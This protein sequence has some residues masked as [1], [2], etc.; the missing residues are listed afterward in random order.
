MSVKSIEVSLKLVATIKHGSV[1][2]IIFFYYIASE[3]FTLSSVDGFTLKSEW[4]QVPSGLQDS[5]KYSARLQQCYSLD[6]LGSSSDFQ[7]FQP[8][9]K[10]FRNRS[11]CTIYNNYHRPQH[12]SHFLVL[13]QGPSIFLSFRRLLFSPCSRLWQQ[14]P[15]FGWFSF[16]FFSFLF[17][18]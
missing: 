17:F 12:V 18:C 1:F 13:K 5:S 15:L 6:G 2:F 14:S 16:F 3:F 11:K 8:P 10:A 4:H 7:L 9:Y